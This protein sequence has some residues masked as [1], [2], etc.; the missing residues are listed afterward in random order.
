MCCS[1]RGL[2]FFYRLANGPDRARVD[3]V[4]VLEGKEAAEQSGSHDEDAGAEQEGDKKF[5]T[6]RQS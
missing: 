1:L 5:A 2:F 4:D 6:I 3:P